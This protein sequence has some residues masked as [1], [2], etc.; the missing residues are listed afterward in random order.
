MTCW[1]RV[2]VMEQPIVTKEEVRWRGREI[3]EDDKRLALI[4]DVLERALVEC[5]GIAH[6]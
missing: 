1:M 2:S 4:G 3:G 5:L 6:A